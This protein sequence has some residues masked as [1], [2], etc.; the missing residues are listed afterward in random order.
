MLVEGD[1]SDTIF[2]GPIQP[3][4]NRSNNKSGPTPVD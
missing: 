4:L 3:N 1:V 2:I